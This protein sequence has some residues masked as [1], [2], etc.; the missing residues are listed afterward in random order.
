M[1]VFSQIVKASNA[2]KISKIKNLEDKSIL[3]SGLSMLCSQGVCSIVQ[4]KCS[5]Q[6]KSI[7][8]ANCTKFLKR[9][10]QAIR[11]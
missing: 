5:F 7:V 11:C 10:K 1:D 2:L 4:L 6:F 9:L 8:E 3:K